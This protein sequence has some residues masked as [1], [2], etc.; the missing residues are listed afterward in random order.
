MAAVEIDISVEQMRLEPRHEA[1]GAEHFWVAAAWI[2]KGRIPADIDMRGADRANDDFGDEVLGALR[3]KA[4]IEM[5]HE[6]EVD[7]EPRQLT[8][9]DAVRRQPER[10]GR[11]EE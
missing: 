4:E 2:A 3:G 9:L 6:Q 5:L 8:L 11:R 10:L 1:A 7:A